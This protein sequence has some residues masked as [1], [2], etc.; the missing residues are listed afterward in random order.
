MFFN[1]YTK[2]TQHCRPLHGSVS[3]LSRRHC[4][5]IT[6]SVGPGLLVRSSTVS[7]GEGNNSSPC[8]CPLCDLQLSPIS[9]AGWSLSLGAE[10]AT[11]K[12]HSLFLH[13]FYIYFLFTVVLFS[14]HFGT[15]YPPPPPH[16]HTHTL[17]HPPHHRHAPIFSGVG[18][19]CFLVSQVF[20]FL[21]S[22]VFCFLV[23]Q[24]FCFLVSLFF[25][26][27]FSLVFCFLVSLV[28]LPRGIVERVESVCVWGGGGGVID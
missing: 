8:H 16:T 10:H 3:T 6:Y 23:S 22:L 19:A 1:C 5:I 7:S 26:F 20:C 4:R 21:V 15:H 25:C 9:A 28:H 13:F 18:L 27:L 12:R 24:V 2:L 11:P 14:V 17:S